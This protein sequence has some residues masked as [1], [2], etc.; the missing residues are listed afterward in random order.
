VKGLQET[1]KVT[2]NIVLISEKPAQ[3]TAE[4]L[5]AILRIKSDHQPQNKRGASTIAAANGVGK[6]PDG[7]WGNA[8]S[9]LSQGQGETKHFEQSGVEEKEN[10]SFSGMGVDQNKKEGIAQPNAKRFVGGGRPDLDAEEE[11][12]GHLKERGGGGGGR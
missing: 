3:R 10:L 2:E 1:G 6:H 8:F 7:S 9:R 4:K 11:K 12:G 5:P